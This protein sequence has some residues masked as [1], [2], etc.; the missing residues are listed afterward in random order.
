MI[1]M[2]SGLN[3]EK[4]PLLS[5]LFKNTGA[6]FPI[7]LVISKPIAEIFGIDPDYPF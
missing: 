3:L 7:D 2:R 6:Q 4:W 1:G 5:I